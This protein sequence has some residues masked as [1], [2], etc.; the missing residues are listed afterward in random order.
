[1][2][3]NQ[4]NSLNT[5][6]QT[7]PTPWGLKMTF[8]FSLII[9]LLFIG[10]QIMVSFGLYLFKITQ[11]PE[12]TLNDY[13]DSLQNNGLLLS[14]STCTTTLL[15]SPLILLFVWLRK[16]IS[17]RDYLHLYPVN[18]LFLIRWLGV[19]LL[20]SLTFDSLNTLLKLPIVPEFM[21]KVYQTSEHL[22]LLWFTIVVGGPLFEELFFFE[23]FS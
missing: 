21:I 20:L 18:R 22:P 23:G 9:A 6:Q 7:R 15:L 10:L 1:M 12:L 11:H 19:S 16:N 17:I 4:T 2:N 13:I 8:V 5:S 3:L 14:L